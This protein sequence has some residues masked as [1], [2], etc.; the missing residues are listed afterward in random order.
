M[1]ILISGGNGRFSKEL[2]KQNTTHTI[3]P[4]SKTEMNIKYLSSIDSAIK[5][6]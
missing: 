2:I 1:K 6:Y 4:L 5:K 3:I